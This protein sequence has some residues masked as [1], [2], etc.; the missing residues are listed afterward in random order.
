MFGAAKQKV[1]QR[2]ISLK[3]TTFGIV[4]VE[5]IPSASAIDYGSLIGMIATGVGGASLVRTLADVGNSNNNRVLDD[6]AN[7]RVAL[8]FAPVDWGALTT[9]NNLPIV[10]FVI[11]DN[12]SPF[13]SSTPVFYI[14][15][16]GGAFSPNGTDVLTLNLTANPVAVRAYGGNVFDPYLLELIRGNRYPNSTQLSLIYCESAP[17]PTWDTLSQVTGRAANP[18]GTELS[19]PLIDL[20]GG[21]GNRVQWVNDVA[22]GTAGLEFN[23]VILPAFA[24]QSGNPVTHYILCENQ[25][26]YSSSKLVSWGAVSPAL[27]TTGTQDQRLEM[28]AGSTLTL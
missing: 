22:N 14:D 26:P 3:T 13:S 18:G 1:L 23:S 19:T 12:P 7:T 5:S 10:G 8:Q 27:N 15:M 4:P 11:V 16:P 2:N 6:T 21:S 28:A 9:T 17:S 25:P 24:T 20:P